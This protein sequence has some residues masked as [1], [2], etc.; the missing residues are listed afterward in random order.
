MG[1]NCAPR[2]MLQDAER[3]GE[4][5]VQ[6]LQKLADLAQ[7]ELDLV[8]HKLED[9]RSAERGADHSKVASRVQSVVKRVARVRGCL[10]SSIQSLQRRQQSLFAAG[11]SSGSGYSSGVHT[12][13][14][15]VHE[16]AV[17]CIVAALIKAEVN[18]LFDA[19]LCVITELENACAAGDE[20]EAR[21]A[22][23]HG[24]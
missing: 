18:L 13:C 16:A 14:I 23:A 11:A 6:Q 15:L 7:E 24:P 2:W 17:C 1:V 4:S 10:L 22:A 8:H 21:Q 20:H 3:V 12:A 9:A 19:G 5:L